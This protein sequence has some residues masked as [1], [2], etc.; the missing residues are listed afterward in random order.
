MNTCVAL[1]CSPQAEEKLELQ[2]SSFWKVLRKD[3][4]VYET[5][6]DAAERR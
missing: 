6:T 1:S 2:K 4:D 3:R 5:R